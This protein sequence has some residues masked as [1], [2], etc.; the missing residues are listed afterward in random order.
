MPAVVGAGEPGFGDSAGYEGVGGI[1]LDGSPKGSFVVVEDDD[2]RVGEGRTEG[3]QRD[4]LPEGLELGD[5]G[6]LLAGVEG[7][8]VGLCDGG[9]PSSNTRSCRRVR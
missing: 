8:E 3:E 7:P 6:A 2:V 4:G 5:A 9:A 1:P